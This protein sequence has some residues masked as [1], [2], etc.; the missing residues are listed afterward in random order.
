M[1]L[2]SGDN[3]TKLRV[4]KDRKYMLHEI[5]PSTRIMCITGD[6]KHYGFFTLQAWIMI[7]D[8][9][10]I[11]LGL[12]NNYGVLTAIATICKRGHPNNH[13]WDWQGTAD[14]GLRTYFSNDP[15]CPNN[16][17]MIRIEINDSCF[18][19]YVNGDRKGEYIVESSIEKIQIGFEQDPDG[20]ATPSYDILYV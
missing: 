13:R 4:S 17:T 19:L 5:P 11:E 15:I 16:K 12:S 18:S 14:S 3:N 10:I 1:Y 20:D 6:T 2:V 8:D 7:E 9:Y